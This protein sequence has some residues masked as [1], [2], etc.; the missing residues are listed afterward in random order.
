MKSLAYFPLLLALV[1]FSCQPSTESTVQEAEMLAEQANYQEPHR[2]QFHFSPAANWMNDPNGMVFFEGEYHLFY[3]YYPDAMVWGPMHWGHAVSTDLVRWEHL[4]IALYPD[5]LGYIF[6]GS[7]VVDW[8][9]R[10][11][12][13]TGTSPALVAIYTYHDPTGEKAGRNDFQTQGIA[14]SNDRGRTWTKYEDNPVVPNPGIKDFRDPKVFWHQDSE[15]WVMIFA[16]GDRVRIFN[17]PDLK[18]WQ[19][20]SEFGV[21]QGSHDG[22][23]ECPDL[24]PLEVA[25]ETKWVMIVSLGS[26]GANGGS[27]TMYFVGDFD[28]KTFTNDNPAETVLWLDHGRDNYAG[29]TWSDIPEADGRRIFLGWMSN[30]AYATKVPTDPWRSAM[31]VARTLEL[32]NTTEGIRL[33]SKPVREMEGLREKTHALPTTSLTGSLDLTAEFGLASPL[34]QIGVVL[35]PSDTNSGQIG[36]AFSNSSGQSFRLGVDLETNQVFI[37]RTEAGEKDFEASFAGKHTAPLVQ[38]PSGQLHLHVL[39]DVS[40]VELFAQEG[41]V[42]MTDLFFPDTPY[43]QVEVFGE[44]EIVKGTV[45]ELGGIW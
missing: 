31:T 14:Y 3:Q 2:P 10:A 7:A 18:A 15:Q 19:E 26:G 44:G 11:G 1:F 29:V 28:G 16:S 21:D 8:D 5:E 20:V 32:A 39:L 43:D 34:L 41:A 38:L 36:L 12:F 27:G 40:S 22:V 30:W 25:G 24:F 17:S 23:W 33:V 9:N 6:S 42:V 35:D 13:Q 45:W 4:P 37:D